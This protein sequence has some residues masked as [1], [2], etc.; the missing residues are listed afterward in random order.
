ME[1]RRCIALGL[2]FFER[3]VQRARVVFVATE[4]DAAAGTLKVGHLSFGLN[5]MPGAGSALKT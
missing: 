4:D 3:D 1:L 5:L 2:P